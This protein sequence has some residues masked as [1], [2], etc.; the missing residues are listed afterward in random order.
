MSA[1]FLRCL[2][3]LGCSY[4]TKEILQLEALRAGLGVDSRLEEPSSAGQF[5][6]TLGVRICRDFFWGWDVP[7]K[8]ASLGPGGGLGRVLGA[9][10]KLSLYFL[11]FN[12]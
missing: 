10:C 7:F 4:L 11:V 9:F 1:A 12:R 5:P 8:S 6:A 2:M 3:M